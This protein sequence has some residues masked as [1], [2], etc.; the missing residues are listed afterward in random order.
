[1]TLAR[2]VLRLVLLGELLED[3]RITSMPNM[4][5]CQLQRQLAVTIVARKVFS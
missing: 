4:I 5:G 1:M 3:G 2:E